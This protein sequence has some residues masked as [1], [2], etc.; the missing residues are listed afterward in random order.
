MINP[1]KNPVITGCII[2]IIFALILGLSA[3]AAKK[4]AVL[5]IERAGV[6]SGYGIDEVKEAT[7]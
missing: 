3:I 1:I 7:K 4:A 5:I 6:V 2:G